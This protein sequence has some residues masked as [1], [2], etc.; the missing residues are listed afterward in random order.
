MSFTR[1]CWR[2]DMLAQ[3]WYLW[4]IFAL[5]TAAT[6]CAVVFASRAVS[7]HNAEVKKQLEELKRLKLLKDKYK[8]FNA[9]VIANSDSAEVLE[10]ATAVIQAEIEKAEDPEK[11][12]GSFTG[13]QRYVYTL[14]YFLEDAGTQGLSFFFKNNGDELRSI[15][16]DA[17]SAAGC[18]SMSSTVR[19]MWYLFDDSRA[20]SPMDLSELD[21]LD[22][23]FEA[24]FDKNA[25]LEKIRQYVSDNADLLRFKA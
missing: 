6:V 20:E 1:L 11:V 22:S 13:P 2:N 9:D 16:A 8:D 21:R 24:V 25:L 4:V 10:G 3:S 5:L 12:F 23:Q 19:A 17:L 15:A 14:Y 7:S 18:E